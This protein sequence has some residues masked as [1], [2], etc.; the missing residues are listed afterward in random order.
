MVLQHDRTM[1]RLGNDV[2]R[3]YDSY[4]VSLEVID[5]G[6]C[7][8]TPLWKTNVLTYTDSLTSSMGKVAI[9]RH[10]IR[11]TISRNL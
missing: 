10:I 6:Y 7:P 11:V 1:T 9:Y 2:L 3:R 8:H 5:I 4:L